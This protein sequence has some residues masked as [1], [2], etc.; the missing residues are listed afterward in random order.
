MSKVKS[1]FIKIWGFI[2]KFRWYGWA[3]IAIVI[4][5]DLL[6]YYLSHFILETSGRI[7]IAVS[8]KIDVIDN[9]FPVV[10]FFVII[11]WYSY[12]FWGFAILATALTE[13]HNFI[14]MVISMLVVE[15]IGFIIY[16]A[17]PTYLDRAKE[18]LLDIGK[19]PGFC[20]WLLSTTYALDGG[21]F[22]HN[23]F[24]SFHC[25]LALG[26]ALGTFRRKDS[27]LWWRIIAMIS[28]VLICL[29]T[30]FTKQHYFIDVVGGIGLALICFYLTKLINPGKRIL[31]KLETKRV[32][33]EDRQ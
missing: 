12:L 10:P 17:F 33:K 14:N 30:L 31:E 8:P 1:F 5:G 2:K 23:L 29:S 24:P 20:N 18:G 26:P 16:I 32:S 15:A 9:C 21:E 6:I 27:P 4:T 19:Q 7:A 25:I 13:K 28:V 11:Y 3:G 22:G